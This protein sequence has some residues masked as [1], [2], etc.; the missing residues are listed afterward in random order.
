MGKLARFNFNENTFLTIRS[1]PSFDFFSF[2]FISFWP[3]NKM[4]TES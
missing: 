2:R 3:W 1:P 4:K